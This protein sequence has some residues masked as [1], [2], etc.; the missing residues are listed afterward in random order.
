ML[1]NAPATHSVT[2]EELIALIVAIMQKEYE[3]NLTEIVP[4]EA[5]S[6]DAFRTE[7]AISALF[8]T[9]SASD[10][11]TYTCI[12]TDDLGNQYDC[13]L[14][15]DNWQ[16]WTISN[17][18]PGAMPMFCTEADRAKEKA[19]AEAGPQEDFVVCPECGGADTN[20]MTCE[21]VGLVEIEGPADPEEPEEREKL[22]NIYKGQ[23][24]YCGLSNQHSSVT[25]L[26][27]KLCCNACESRVIEADF[28]E[29]HFPTHDDH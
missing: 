2:P 9:A 26:K 8:Q 3:I 5:G 29:N 25:S 6:N 4:D 18:R 27:K 20:C 24:I 28:L 7:Y 1:F 22:R 12:V 14:C 10:N 13:T 16:Y 23:V 11:P 21:G 17:P 15:F 19:I